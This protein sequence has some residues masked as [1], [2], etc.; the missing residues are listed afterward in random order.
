MRRALCL[1]VISFV[2]SSQAGDVILDWNSIALGAVRVDT[3]GPTP[4][5]GP[6]WASRNLAMV[7][8]AMYD[9]VNLIDNAGNQGYQ[10]L[11]AMGMAQ[12][13]WSKEAAAAQAARDVL[14]ALYPNQLG[15]FDTALSNSLSGIANGTA[16]TQGIALGQNVASQILA[17]RANDGAGGPSSYV[18]QGGIGHWSSDPFNPGQQ[19]LSPEWG[20]VTP[21]ALPT[22]W[23]N[24]FMALKP[25]GLDSA[26]YTAAYNE[27]KDYGD[28]NSAVRT[29]DQADIGKYWGY[30]V[31]GLGPP[32]I[33][34]NQITQVIAENQ[35][36]SLEENA[37][38]FALV[39]VAQADGGIVCWGTKYE[40]DFWRPV[41]GIQMGDFDGNPNT[42]GDGDWMPL[43][44][45]GNGIVNNFTPPFPAYTSGHATF[46]AATFEAIADFYGTHNIAFEFASDEFPNQPDKIRS[47]NNLNEAIE[48][49]GQSRIYLG[50]HWAFD[51]TE[52]IDCGRQVAGYIFETSMQAVPEPSSLILA[53]LAGGL[54][55]VAT[56]RRRG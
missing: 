13:S 41:T 39:N 16:K 31:G 1:L 55:I 28:K 32:P 23:Q 18:P 40:Y 22:N 6:V 35:G 34:Y 42:I 25:P 9:A 26:A 3:S 51:K 24:Q 7:H 53:G 49:N 33:L 36:N 20:K 30:D 56:A 52:G 15:T 48:E 46:G 8:V 29:Q 10:P 11:H 5:P 43:G 4:T 27:V 50:I 17:W 12:S 2:S 14:A 37:R 38:L 54:M 19:P 21:F 45:P 47:F 44:A